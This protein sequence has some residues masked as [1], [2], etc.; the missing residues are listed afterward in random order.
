MKSLILA[1]SMIAIG[2]WYFHRVMDDRSQARTPEEAPSGEIVVAGA[3][4][5]SLQ[6]RWHNS[7]PIP[8]SR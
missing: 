7:T 8:H 4:D 5:G 3:P 1:A 6:Q 2:A